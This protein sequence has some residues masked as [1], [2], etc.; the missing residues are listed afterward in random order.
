MRKYKKEDGVSYALGAAPTLELLLHKPKAA[1][2]VY[3]HSAFEK[4]EA[5]YKLSALC[6]KN[7]VE[8]VFSDKPFSLLSG[9]EN[10][11]VIGAFQKFESPLNQKENHVVLVNPSNMG[12]LGT[13]VRTA[14]GFHAG[15]LAV[16][17][18][19]ADL[20]DPRTVRASMGAVFRIN[21]GYFDSFQDYLKEAGER[22]VPADRT[23]P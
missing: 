21:F 13:I 8:M 15:N 23:D 14:A 7:D 18:P 22:S 20:F 4:G 17:R 12:N 11:F 2:A 19:A 9:K 16:V 10:C 1:A 3:V 5:F 6:E